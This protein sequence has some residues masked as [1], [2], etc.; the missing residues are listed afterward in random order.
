MAG[1][2]AR[3]RAQCLPGCAS[4][5][6]TSRAHASDG[7]VARHPVFV[8]CDWVLWVFH[9]VAARYSIADGRN[10]HADRS[11]HCGD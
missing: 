11:Y 8:G 7:L 1:Q 10:G 2:R 3:D 6:D 5:H 9:V 4:S